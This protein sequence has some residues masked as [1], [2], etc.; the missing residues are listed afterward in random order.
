[1]GFDPLYMANEG[2]AVFIVSKED[3][4]IVLDTLRQHPYGRDARIIGEVVEQPA[5][6]VLMKTSYHSTRMLDMLSG[7]TLPR[8]C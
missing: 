1:M 5:R 6:R 4:E 3:A 8:T 2:K 7:E